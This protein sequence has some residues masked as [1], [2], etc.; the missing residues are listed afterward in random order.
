MSAKDGFGRLG[1]SP[2][3]TFLRCDLRSQA[4][5]GTLRRAIF[6]ATLTDVQ[7]QSLQHGLDGASTINF[8]AHAQPI[9]LACAFLNTH[10]LR[11]PSMTDPRNV[12]HD[13]KVN[14]DKKNHGEEIAPGSEHAPQPGQKPRMVKDETAD[15]DTDDS[16]D[17]ETASK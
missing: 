9:S 7:R 2:I 5:R 8:Q 10:N 12:A 16:V 11:K 3:S 13:K 1:H 6:A 4:A 15:T 14:H 17:S